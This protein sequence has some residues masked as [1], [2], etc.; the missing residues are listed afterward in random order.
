MISPPKSICALLAT[1]ALLL[2][3]CGN[4]VTD[5]VP[6]PPSTAAA[7]PP[8]P[9][10]TAD[11]PDSSDAATS[12]YSYPP[13]S[14]PPTVSAATEPFPLRIAPEDE[15]IEYVRKDY[16]SF[17][18]NVDRALAWN[19]EGCKWAFYAKAEEDCV[20][21]GGSAENNRDHMV[22]VVDA[23]KSG[24]NLWNEERKRDFYSWDANLFVMPKK[25]NSS[26]GGSDPAGWKP[27]NESDWC[28]YAETWIDIKT[29]W[30][31]AADAAE[32]EALME[33][34]DTC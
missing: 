7:V 1:S 23:H 15:S 21:E 5:A 33:M 13:V 6:Q 31:L 34:L 16:G 24:G 32:A 30:E 9:A 12:S 2:A 3:A 18:S 25:E 22:P 10:T 20:P 27:A 11:F 8:T 26:K 29:E 14:P 17:R 28:L 4:S 19:M